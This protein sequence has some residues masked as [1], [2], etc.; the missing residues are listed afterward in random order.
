M[1]KEFEELKE[2]KAAI[3]SGT[4]AIHLSGDDYSRIDEFVEKLALALDFIESE[5]KQVM[6]QDGPETQTEEKAQVVEWNYGYGQVDFFSRAKIGSEGEKILFPRFLETYK[7]KRYA[8]K[9]IILIRNARHVLEGEFN[10]ENL[11][12]L[13]Q[14]IIHLKKKLPGKAA[15][16]Y[17][18]ETR[19]IP[20]ELSSLVHYIDIKPPSREELA[21]ITLEFIN[22]KGLP[23][24]PNLVYKLS[25]M[26]VGMS[27]DSFTQILK[28]AETDFADTVIPLAAKT[29]KQFVDKSDLLKYVDVAVD[30]N[31][32][33]GGLDYLKWWLNQEKKAFENPEAARELG[34]NPAKGILLVGMP[35]CGKSLTSK[36]VAAFFGLPLLQLDLGTLMGKYVGDSEGNLRRALRLAENSSPCVLWVD[37]IEKAFA[38]VGGDESGVSQRLFGY[39]LTWLNDKTA[40]VFVMATANDV[41]ILPPEFLRRGRF[42]E[43]FYVDFPSAPERKEIFKI[44]LGKA[45]GGKEKV[46]EILANNKTL[47]EKFEEL[48]RDRKPEETGS[49]TDAVVNNIVQALSKRDFYKDQ[50]EKRIGKEKVGKILGDHYSAM[51]FEELIHDIKPEG[52]TGKNGKPVDQGK[53]VMDYPGTE[54]YAGSDIESL[55]NAAI[56]R[57]WNQ[58]KD[59][60]AI[61]TD[62]F[63]T[64][65]EERVHMTPLKEVLAE[66]IKLN[67]EKFGQYKL[68]SASEKETNLRRF[69]INSDGPD[70]EAQIADAKDK[71]C[72]MDILIKYSKKGT[73][74]VKLAVLENQNCPAMCIFDL[75]EDKD[76][77]VKAKAQEKHWTT[78]EGIIKIAQN[79]TKEQKHDLLTREI[80][81]ETL[82]YLAKD[83]RCPAGILI[84]MAKKDTKEVK[85][86]VLDHPNFPSVSFM[87]FMVDDDADV[88]AKAEEKWLATPHGIGTIALA[89][90]GT[91][92]DI[93]GIMQRPFIPEPVWAALI[94]RAGKD[95]EIKALLLGYPFLPEAKKAQ[96]HG[97]P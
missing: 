34:I 60:E 6:G 12:Q 62:I 17:C 79:G 55:V 85:L 94:G 88:K 5:E 67:R 90:M 46:E 30:I 24:D 32:N 18:D 53:K 84:A 28:K 44:H 2:A 91:R 86:A 56:K 22:R 39:L 38:G 61:K 51:K 41:A 95:Q 52:K 75:M 4:S 3:Q 13:Q 76:A 78:P 1:G 54:G 8:E 73:R 63:D 16:V 64:L 81:R 21:K 27:E 50:L 93:F 69:Q 43:I 47:N 70:E 74:K 82:L 68:T 31:N 80:P 96:L 33:V 57:A 14:T 23:E 92:K 45:F 97:N 65:L 48:T 36:A 49:D 87:D 72:P 26:C 77:D 19:F 58:G 40:R 9:R 7:N 59:L 71:R 11:A 20:D 15:L 37:E 35:G 89:Q 29:K 10:R 42:D 66:K 83:E 25:S